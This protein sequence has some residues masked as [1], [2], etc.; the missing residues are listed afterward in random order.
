LRVHGGER[1][2]AL[3][4]EQVSQKAAQLGDRRLGLGNGIAA[5]RMS[6][7]GQIPQRL[8]LDGRDF[9]KIRLLL[10]QEGDGVIIRGALRPVHECLDR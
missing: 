6:G 9:G 1:P 8:H 10:P 2:I 7:C 5:I 3:G 4:L